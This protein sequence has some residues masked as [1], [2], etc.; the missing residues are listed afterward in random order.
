MFHC[1][2]RQYFTVAMQKR[3]EW[4]MKKTKGAN[5]RERSITGDMQASSGTYDRCTARYNDIASD[6]AT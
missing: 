5:R 2:A 3:R 6:M 1:E 4:R